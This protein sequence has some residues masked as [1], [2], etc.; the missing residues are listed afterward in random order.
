MTLC[1]CYIDMDL[2]KV[3]ARVIVFGCVYEGITCFE[4]VIWL[5]E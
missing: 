3:S 2:F 4:R 1:L 5:L